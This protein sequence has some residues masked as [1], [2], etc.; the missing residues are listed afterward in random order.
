MPGQHQAANAAVALATI[1][2]LRHQGSC[3]SADAMRS[4]LSTA[5]LPGRI[6]VL[7]GDNSVILDTAHNP[8]SARALVD[9]L[10]EQPGPTRRTLIL[11]IS[12][13]KDVA[14]I[15][16]Q[17]SPHFDR[18]VVTQYQENPRAVPAENLAKIV[19]GSLLA[20]GAEVTVCPTPQETWRYVCRTMLPGERVCI[21][22]SF[23]LAAEMRPLVQSSAIS[24]TVG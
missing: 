22:G 4:G 14:A 15:V 5:K 8:A 19:R 10:R 1:A 2:E 23:Y 17:L 13:D 9:T 7:A 18:F 12:H 20:E 16:E 21:T 6:E 24:S 3:V 11:S